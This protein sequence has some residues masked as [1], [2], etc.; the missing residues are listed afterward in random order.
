MRPPHASS[1][2]LTL[3]PRIDSLISLGFKFHA[4]GVEL[5]FEGLETIR[6]GC[7]KVQ[8]LVPAL[9]D[10]VDV[11]LQLFSHEVAP[12]NRGPVC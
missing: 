9:L 5:G 1:H 4:D 10:P 7:Q 8:P 6:G 12:A 2:A 3:G 11:F